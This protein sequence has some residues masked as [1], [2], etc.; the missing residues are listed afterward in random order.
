MCSQV[1][2]ASEPKGQ[3][4][5]ESSLSNINCS[6]T[7]VI[8]NGEQDRQMRVFMG[9]ESQCSYIKR[10]TARNMKFEPIGKEGLIHGLFGGG[11][12]KSL[13]RLYY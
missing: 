4:V 1:A 8:P 12:T 2:K 3:P 9:P 10:G 11:T 7:M 13:Q 5:V 6:I